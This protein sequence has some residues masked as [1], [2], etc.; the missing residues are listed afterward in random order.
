M[1]HTRLLL[2]ALPVLLAQDTATA[3]PPP[4]GEVAIVREL[5]APHFPGAILE[6]RQ[7]DGSRVDLLTDTH[8]IEADWAS[9]LHWAQGVGQALYYQILTDRQPGLLL[10]V[11]DL[12]ADR[13]ELHRAQAVCAKHSIRL[14][15]FDVANGRFLK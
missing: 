3:P 12:A 13:E 14:W 7:W 9:G 4:R 15:I 2:L 8:A 1:T 6:A 11:K 5:V 10:L